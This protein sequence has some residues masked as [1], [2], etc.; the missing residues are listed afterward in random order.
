MADI[1]IIVDSSEVA[2]ATNR[3][4]QLGNS[5]KVAKKGIDKATRGMNQFGAVAKN[6]GK[7]MNTFNMQLQQGG[8]QLQ[9]FVVQ[10][11]SGTSFFTA[12]GQQGSQFAGVFGPK[13]AVIGAVIAIGSAVGGLLVNSLMGASK[14]VGNLTDA[15]TKY[16]SLS[17]KIADS[18]GL[19]KEF[20]K[21]VVEARLIIEALKAIEGIS[22]KK[23]LAELGGIGKVLE[24]T[25]KQMTMGGF[26]NLVPTFQEITHLSAKT[27]TSAQDFL[28]LTEGTVAEM[29]VYAGEYARAL[30]AV[31]SA[32]TLEAQAE[33]AGKL[34]KFLKEHVELHGEDTKNLEQITE[35]QEV[36]MSLMATTAAETR[37]TSDSMK[38]VYEYSEKDEAKKDKILKA[39]QAIKKN[40]ND[41]LIIETRRIEVAQA[42]VNLDEVKAKHAREDYE[43]KKKSEGILGKNL[44]EAMA[45]YDL[46]QKVIKSEADRAAA[47]KQRGAEEKKLAVENAAYEKKAKGDQIAAIKAAKEAN[48]SAEEQIRLQNQTIALK[49]IEV[50]F[51]K[52]TGYYVRQT[53]RFERENLALKLEQA[54]VDEVHIKSLL[55]GNMVIEEANR[56]LREQGE[57][58]Y[59][60]MEN[61]AAATAMRKYA[62]RSTVGTPPKDPTGTT[63]PFGKSQAEIDAETIASFQK[64][65]DLEDALFG[66]T[67]ARQKVLQALGVDLA[68][69]APKDA[70]RMEAQIT[71][72]N[73]LIA[74]EQRRQALVDSITGSIEDGFMAMSDG[75]KSVSD[76]FRNMAAEIV[77]ELYKVYVMQVAIKALKLAMGIP[78]ADGGVISG[79]SEVKAYADGGIVGGPTT[80]PMAGGKTGLMGEAGPEAIMPL[81]RGANG[82]LGVQAEGGS[83]DIY[84]TNNY[85]IS[86]NTSEDTKRLVTQTIQQAQPALTQAAKAS[87][88]NDRRRGGQMKSVFG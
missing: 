8:Y 30:M 65:L 2:T 5:G 76:A 19:S 21:L 23:Q 71:K 88:M 20:G 3:V 56:L 14:E 58:T 18:D 27:L 38:L 12:F 82:K 7:K 75:T 32:G 63:T 25:S 9:D 33:A 54:G 10:L 47:N 80:F 26:L 41:S 4:D 45:A 49:Q 70:A 59:R 61:S 29:A 78:F 53:A 79:G 68:A 66:K 37:N 44:K 16:K 13:G 17:D 34:S 81:K 55:E 31:Q 51:G 6:G 11:Q 46:A 35:L 28:G 1:K 43:L 73:E 87:I 77:R 50:K 83:G 74:V 84:V 48:D 69:K 86:A 39:V 24:T 40:L 15:L 22:I 72:T 57:I 36:L 64:Q 42:G 67:E 85:S 60:I 62:G 52:E